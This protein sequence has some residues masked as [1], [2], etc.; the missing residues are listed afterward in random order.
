MEII[1][2]AG[3]HQV[4]SRLGSVG[5]GLKPYDNLAI[6]FNHSRLTYPVVDFSRLSLSTAQK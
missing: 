6:S 5:L 4:G 2:S 1:D 3:L